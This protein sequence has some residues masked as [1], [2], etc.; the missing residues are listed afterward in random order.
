MALAARYGCAMLNLSNNP[1]VLTFPRADPSNAAAQ[2][3]VQHDAKAVAAA[4]QKE[5]DLGYYVPSGKYWKEEA[6]FDLTE[7]DV[8]DATWL[9]LAPPAQ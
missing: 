8:L 5:R 9:A 4:L 3:P 6:R 2:M 7:I 1:S